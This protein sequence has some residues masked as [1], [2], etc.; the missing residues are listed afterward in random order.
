M[1]I[2]ALVRTLP[3]LLAAVLAACGQVPHH[4]N[5]LAMRLLKQEND[6]LRAQVARS[7][8]QTVPNVALTGFDGTSVAP[9]PIALAASASVAAAPV[10]PRQN[11][12]VKVGT[13]PYTGTPE[14]AMNL[15][16][17]P[18]GPARDLVEA[19][20]N[21]RGRQVSMPDGVVYSRQ[22]Y[23]VGGQ[24]RSWNNIQ[25]KL[26]HSL[27]GMLYTSGQYVVFYPPKADGGCDNY[28]LMTADEAKK[29]S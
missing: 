14:Q 27:E 26:G 13:N 8:R 6:V 18:E 9:R 23:S 5:D 19:I 25:Q 2:S 7:G 15:L 12:W 24:H 28:S 16:G 4:N 11:I 20:K 3:L 22:V 1:R 17:I 10:A 29:A 21:G